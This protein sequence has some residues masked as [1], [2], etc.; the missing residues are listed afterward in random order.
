MSR[1]GGGPGTN[2]YG[3]GRGKSARP[4]AIPRAAE[5]A[6]GVSAHDMTYGATPIEPDHYQFLLPEHQKLSTLAELA[7]VEAENIID[8]AL[9]LD[10]Q[11]VSVGQLLTQQFLRELHQ[12]MFGH[13]WTWAG[14]LRAFESNMGIDPHEIAVR[15]EQVLG[16]TLWQFESE[17][18]DKVEAGVRFH[19]Q[20][21][22]VHCFTN[23]NGRH[24]RLASNKLAEASGLGANLYTWGQRTAG[25]VEEARIAYIDALAH[26]DK[27]DD[28]GPLVKLAT[29]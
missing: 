24:A 27:T 13:V 12:R 25:S 2:Q 21:L 19:R 28:Y 14:S 23:G 3:R 8:A 10:D 4:Q 29:S 9:W 18:L 5:V 7:E 15:W 6:L 16:N 20:M 17:G 22:A 26:A 11:D 1:T